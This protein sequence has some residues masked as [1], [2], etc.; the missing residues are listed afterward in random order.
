MA[1]SVRW[2]PHG[3][4]PLGKLISNPSII[5]RKVFGYIASLVSRVVSTT[6]SFSG[7]PMEFWSLIGKSMNRRLSITYPFEVLR[8]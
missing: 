3:H 7:M 5:N 1:V 8:H 6:S 2:N 4:I